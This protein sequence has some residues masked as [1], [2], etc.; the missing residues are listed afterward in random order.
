M[1]S[2][3]SIESRR[4]QRRR[5]RDEMRSNSKDGSKRSSQSPPIQSRVVILAKNPQKSTTSSSTT[6][7]NQMSSTGAQTIQIMPSLHST[8]T[9]ANTSNSPSVNPLVL[10]DELI[11]DLV[12][13]MPTVMKLIES[14]TLL[15]LESPASDYLLSDSISSGGFSVISAVGLEGVGKSSVLNKIAGK[16]VFKVHNNNRNNNSDPLKHMTRGIDLHITKE[17]LLLLDSQV[18]QIID[19][20]LVLK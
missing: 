19:L 1:D 4:H 13:N 18:I 11:T 10:T 8:Q 5:N 16:E 15:F 17:R 2:K 6:S 20:F 14:E 9:N 3:L 12:S 7:Q